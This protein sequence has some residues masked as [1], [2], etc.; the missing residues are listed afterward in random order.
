MQHI[1]R[2]PPRRGP[3]A[4]NLIVLA[5]RACV[6]G[7]GDIISA[8]GVL[9]QSTGGKSSSSIGTNFVRREG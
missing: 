2:S 7:D 5:V 4:N 9:I 8:G 1:V 6:V 3:L